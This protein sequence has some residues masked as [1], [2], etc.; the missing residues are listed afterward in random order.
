MMMRKHFINRD[1]WLNGRAKQ[2]IGAS[3]AGSIAGCGFQSRIDLWKLK[4]GRMKQR[5]LSGVAEVAEGR[6][7]EE[8]IR[9]FYRAMHPDVTVN[10]YPYDILYQHDRPW[11]FAT[12]DGEIERSGDGG[13]ERGILEIKNVTPSGKA[14]WE[15]WDKRIPDKYYFQILHQLLATGFRFAVLYAALHGADGSV[16]LR[17]YEFRREDVQ[18]D[19]DYYLAMAAEFWSYVQND[20][21]PPMP[22]G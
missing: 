2:G 20:R 19:M 18:G 21:M 22:I 12:L 7:M 17:E 10:H 3:E 1:T 6:R 4:T 8:P 11:L 16:T 5:D 15:E 9:E 13:T 14:G